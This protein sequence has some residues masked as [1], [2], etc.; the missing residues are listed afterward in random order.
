MAIRLNGVVVL[1]D[2]TCKACE[3]RCT[4]ETSASLED[5]Q[6]RILV[7][8]GWSQDGDLLLGPNCSEERALKR[9]QA[10]KVPDP[11]DD[12]PEL[13]DVREARLAV[14]REVVKADLENREA[15]LSELRE[16]VREVMLHDGNVP[17]F[18]GHVGSPSVRTEV[19]VRGDYVEISFHE[20]LEPSVK[21]GTGPAMSL[22]LKHDE[23]ELVAP[24][25]FVDP[26]ILEWVQN[27]LRTM[28]PEEVTEATAPVFQ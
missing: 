26:I 16:Y 23:L 1:C 27:C 10:A 5:G 21:E 17:N 3:H 7:P 14:M 13:S 22:V 6:L 9:V 28:T 2:A 15:D 18:L 19:R 24:P 4:A 11:A 25:K 8:S 12:P 20:G